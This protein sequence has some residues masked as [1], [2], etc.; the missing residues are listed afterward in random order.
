M[1]PEL[2]KGQRKYGPKVDVWSYGIFA[3]ELTNGDPP[4]INEK[5]SRAIIYICKNEPPKIADKWSA[6]FKDFV[7]KCLVKDPNERWSADQLLE[8]D[9]LY[10][11]QEY[12]EEF[13]QCV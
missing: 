7:S 11:A 4:Y 1:A 10:N 3:Y 12:Q 5:Q 6:L 8:H 9:F 2:I 13:S